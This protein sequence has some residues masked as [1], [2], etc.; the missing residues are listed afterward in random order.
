MT[1]GPSLIERLQR[2]V[3]LEDMHPVELAAVAKAASTLEDQARLI[4][5]CAQRL[6]DA[7]AQLLHLQHFPENAVDESTNELMRLIDTL[8]TKLNA[9]GERAA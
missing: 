7:R 2:M 4:G 9:F 5:E 1:D 6:G 3:R 8:L